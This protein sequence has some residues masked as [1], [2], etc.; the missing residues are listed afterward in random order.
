MWN[1]WFYFWSFP[2]LTW[3]SFA[4]LGLI[5]LTC[6]CLLSSVSHQSHMRTLFLCFL[7]P[8]SLVC[9]WEPSP[10]CSASPLLILSCFNLF[11]FHFVC[12]SIVWFF[13]MSVYNHRFW[14][15]NTE[16]III[17]HFP[18]H[19]GASRGWDFEPMKLQR[20]EEEL[21]L[22]ETREINER[23]KTLVREESWKNVNRARR[24]D[25]V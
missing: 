13:F 9:L 25:E 22:Y 20:W 1:Y 15:M 4:S 23:K 19:L 18:L 21:R 14:F 6:V 16:T 7:S 10:N 24:S 5:C 12:F 2:C 8:S 11:P 3:V 17:E